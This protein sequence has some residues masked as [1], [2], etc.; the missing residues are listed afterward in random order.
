MPAP[1]LFSR[2]PSAAGREVEPAR[3]PAR[4][5]SP[6]EV[7]P[8]GLVTEGWGAPGKRRVGAALLIS[9]AAKRY[10]LLCSSLCSSNRDS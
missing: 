2:R 7:K 8:E 4:G 3:S 1:G 9:F 10:W 5:L 6:V